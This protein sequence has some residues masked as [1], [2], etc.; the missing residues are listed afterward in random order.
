MLMFCDALREDAR[1]RDDENFTQKTEIT[2]E[3]LQ[4]IKTKHTQ[5][6]Y[7]KVFHVKFAIA[8]RCGISELITA[9]D[10]LH[11]FS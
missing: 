6:L 5:N 2:F 11:V 8:P 9:S 7:I 1:R 3:R 4:Q 10:I